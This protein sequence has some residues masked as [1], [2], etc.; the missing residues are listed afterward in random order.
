MSELDFIPLAVCKQLHGSI[1]RGLAQRATTFK[2]QL[3]LFAK[4]LL[5]TQNSLNNQS[6]VEIIDL[7]SN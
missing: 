7:F 2:D 6:K 3:H 4:L 5:S 1:D